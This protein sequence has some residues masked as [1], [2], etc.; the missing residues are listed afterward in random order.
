MARKRLVATVLVLAALVGLS[1]LSN[2]G[3]VAQIG[4]TTAVV[5]IAKTPT[6]SPTNAEIDIAVRE[7]IALVGGLP[8][9]IGPGKKIVIQPNL[10]Q[11]GWPSGSGVITNVQ[12]IRTVVQMCI[13]MGASPND[14]TICEGAASYRNGTG[15][16]GYTDRQMTLKALKDSGIDPD[17]DL[18]ME[19]AEGNHIAKC[20]DPNNVGTV[21]PNYPGYSGP[22]NSSYV[23]Q[24]VK[25]GFLISRAYYIPNVVAECDVLIRIPVLKN[26]SLAG[27]TGALKLAFG[28]APSDIYH[29][30]GLNYYK[31]ALLHQ[32]SWGYNELTT[33]AR[34]MA[35]MTYC[36]PP[37][38]VVCD[39]LVG[40][41]NGPVGSGGSV[42]TMS[43][44]MACIIAGADPVAVD[45]IHTLAMGYSITSIPGL[46][47]AAALGL[48]TDNPGKIEVRGYHVKDV[49]RNFPAHGC[50]SPGDNTPPTMTGLTVPDGVHVCGQLTVGPTGQFDLNPGLCKGELYIDG[51]LVDS[52]DSSASAF[53]TSWLVTNQS[54]GA[55]TLTYTLYD[56]MLNET[57]LS[58]TVYVHRGNPIAEAQA[59]PDGT[60]V[61]LGTLI[62][63]G[64]TPAIDGNT[65]FVSSPD[66]LQG[67]RVRYGGTAPSLTL[68]QKIAVYG[69]LSSTGGQRYLNC[70]SYTVYEMGN[71]V[72]PR[73]F[74]NKAL[75]GVAFNGHTPGVSNPSGPYNLG[76]LVKTAGKVLSSGSGYFFISDGSV[77]TDNEGINGIKVKCGSISQPAVGSYVT[78]VGLSCCEDDGAA[79]R[80]MLVVRSASDIATH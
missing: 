74:R 68:G 53:K 12:V 22:Y 51:I 18:W 60:T 29:Y 26:H 46:A 79:I 62:Y 38:F 50:G 71:Q 31:W 41:T 33:N 11:A 80:R 69:T 19:D 4:T 52:N 78:V 10:V 43:P 36:R 9:N 15:T 54:D 67:M 66:G 47:Q 77:T 56:K 40:V 5:G 28:L 35:D 75:G 14:I 1:I 59:L 3:T 34:G 7:A 17:G 6:T 63:T 21:Y 8:A 73:Y 48:G 42:T 25:P 64:A 76:C 16:G 20:I 49:R 44:G 13:E 2:L 72:K 57:S 24:V 61:S 45:T 37:D 27:T 23:T 30:P 32:Q 39:G 58:R 70:L 65:F 55:H